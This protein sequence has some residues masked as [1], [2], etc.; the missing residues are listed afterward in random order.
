MHGDLSAR[1]IK[2]DFFRSCSPRHAPAILWTTFGFKQSYEIVPVIG[3]HF[4]ARKLAPFLLHPMIPVCALACHTGPL[5]KLRDRRESFVSF[6]EDPG[7]EIEAMRHALSYEVL[8]RLDACRAQRIKW[9]C[10][11]LI[12]FGRERAVRLIA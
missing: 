12:R 5:Q 11:L 4:M 9:L 7:K 10:A 1:S 3:I 8:N 6:P 2:L